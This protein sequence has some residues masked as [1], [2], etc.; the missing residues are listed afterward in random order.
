[1]AQAL[2]A[3]DVSYVFYGWANPLFVVLMFVSTLIDYLCGLALVGPVASLD[4]A[5]PVPSLPPGEPRT[6]T[7]ALAACDLDHL[8]PLAAGIFQVLQLPRCNYTAL[9]G[10]AGP[11]RHGA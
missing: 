8:E 2:D 10:V 7:P 9:V 5:R 11:D 3:H 1:M 6:T 4:V